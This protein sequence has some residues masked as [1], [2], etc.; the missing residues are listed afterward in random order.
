MAKVIIHS[1]GPTQDC[2][3]EV[4]HFTILTGAQASGKSTIAKCVFFCRTIKDDIY[5]VILKRMLLGNS[6]TLFNDIIKVLRSKFLQIFGTSKA[7][8][9]EMK[10]L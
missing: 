3:M 5:D 9:P 4:E 2:T 1:L 8:N 7:M 10:L 6:N